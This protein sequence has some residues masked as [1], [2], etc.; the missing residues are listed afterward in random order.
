LSSSSSNGSVVGVEGSDDGGG[1]GSPARGPT[2]TPQPGQNRASAGGTEPH[3]GQRD[4]RCP[5]QAMQ[6]LAP[7]AAAW[8]HATQFIPDSVVI[9]LAPVNRRQHSA[10][11]EGAARHGV[12]AT[13]KPF[14]ASS[15]LSRMNVWRARHSLR[16]RTARARHPPPVPPRPPVP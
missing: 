13:P 6:N 12:A 3:R 2:R 11:P 8:P 15:G 4:P 9:A 16:R 7:G 5:P 14:G 10:E 1:V